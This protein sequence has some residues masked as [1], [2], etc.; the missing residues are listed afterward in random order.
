M[1]NNINLTNI[2]GQDIT[3]ANFSVNNKQLCANG[4]LILSGATFPFYYDEKG[5]GW[6][7]FSDLTLE[8]TLNGNPYHVNLNRDHYFGGND[9]HYPGA[10]SD[11]NYVLLGTNSSGSQIQFRLAY[12]QAGAATFLYSSDS[13]VLDK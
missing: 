4:T 1:N 6:N 13:K 8:V 7:D 12:R 11:V 2:T 10:G 9:F 5:K 3:I